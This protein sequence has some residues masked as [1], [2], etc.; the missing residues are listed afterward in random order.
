MIELLC[1][2]CNGAKRK[3]N[4]KKSSGKQNYW[5]NTHNSLCCGRMR[6]FSYDVTQKG[7]RGVPLDAHHNKNSLSN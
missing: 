6:S 4:G 1:P 7:H 2:D 5:L 3:R